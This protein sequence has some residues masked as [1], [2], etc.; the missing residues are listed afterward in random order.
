ML[1][2]RDDSLLDLLFGSFMEI[3]KLRENL[4]KDLAKIAYKVYDVSFEKKDSI[5]HVIIDKPMDLN[6]IE[7][8]SKKVSEIMDKYDEDMPEY[9]LDVSSVGI[10]RPIRSSEE[11]KKAVG[12]YIY[13]KTKDLKLYGDL[14]DFKDDILSLKTKDKNITKTLKINYDELKFV[15][16]AVKF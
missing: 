10:E 7:V 4:E 8:L 13:I 12:S 14:L 2:S 9:L 3:K 15:R 6:E 1:I 16:Y 5:L 11:L